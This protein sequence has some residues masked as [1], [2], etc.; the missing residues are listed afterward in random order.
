MKISYN[1]LKTYLRTDLPAQEAAILLTDCGLEVEHIEHL[2]AVKGGLKGIVVGEVVSKEKHPDADRLSLTKV[3]VG[4]PE[5]L[6]IVCGAPNVAAG[7]KVL[8]AETGAILYPTSGEPFE[9]KKSKIRGQLS[10]GMICA[11]DEIGLGNSHDGIL[12]LDSDAIVGQPAS[13]HLKLQDDEIFE[14]GLTPNRSDAASHLGVARD[15]AAVLNYRAFLNN[16]QPYQL[17]LPEPGPVEPVPTFENGK[18]TDITVED[19]LACPRYC[20]INISGVSIKESPDWLKNRLNSIGLKPINNVVDITNFVLHEL[21]QPLHAFD[22]DKISGDK[23]YVKKLPAKTRFTT[24]DGVQRELNAEDLMICSVTDPLCIAGVY[25]GADSGITASTKNIFLESAWFEAGTIRKTSKR[26]GLKTDASFRFERGTDPEATLFAIRRAALL[27]KEIA[28]GE[29]TSPITDLYPTP[30]E[31]FKVGLSYS[32]CDEFI[33]KK[34]DPKIIKIII[35]SLGIAILS[36]GADAL[37]LS[38][39]PY[40]VDVRREV[41]V[42]EE[43]IRIYGYNNIEIPSALH[44]SVSYAVRPDPEEIQETLS[45]FLSDNGFNE[46]LTNSL[47]RSSHNKETNTEETNTEETNTEETNTEI[48]LLNPL[49]T[50]LQVLRQTLL[51]SGLEVL[52]YNINRKNPNLKFYEFGK[53]YK[54]TASGKYIENKHLALLLTGKKEDENWTPQ[55][56]GDTSFYTLKGIVTAVLGRIGIANP[57]TETGKNEFLTEELQFSSAKKNLA[58]F[59]K[60]KKSLL[61]PF[62]IRQDVFYA[63]FNW[64]NLLELIGRQKT[65]F[66]E[67]PRFPSVRRDLALLLDK[68]VSYEQLREIAFQTEKKFLSQVNIFDVYQGEKLKTDKKSYALSFTLQ[69][70]NETLTDKQIEKI[71][72]RLLKAYTE[73]AGAVIR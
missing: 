7:Q 72:E 35:E 25:G 49:S 14:I 27:I 29:I 54:K 11:E 37:L 71:M 9:I 65:E 31:P 42:I 62:D 20:G 30:A 57:K 1:W 48:T 70:E 43:I 68:Q 34:I 22:A 64:D 3:N 32:Y 33:G 12:I 16:G 55:R 18:K 56:P 21:G 52:S 53:T 61:K 2:S 26:H 24:L 66:S 23:I 59:G 15:L 69:D 44:A 73:K 47:T 8:V 36:E 6:S 41:D 51:F 45:C 5:L 39:P 50:D 10:E 60:V 19:A 28:G 13:E 58:Y 40:K 38:V 4:K 17:E 63:Q 46:I 67:I